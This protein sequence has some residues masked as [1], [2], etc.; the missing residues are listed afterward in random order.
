MQKKVTGLS[1]HLRE[2]RHKPNWKE[3][4]ILAKENNIVKWKFKGTF[5]AGTHY[6]YYQNNYDK[7]FLQRI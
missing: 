2:S 4:E 6:F 7:P 3:V 5:Q 1:Q